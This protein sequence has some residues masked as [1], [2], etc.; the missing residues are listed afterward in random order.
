MLKNNIKILCVLVL[1]LEKTIN[2]RVRGRR[3]LRR[4]CLSIEPL[5]RQRQ[6]P[7]KRQRTI[8]VSSSQKQKE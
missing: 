5:A 1:I 4:R 7:A 6:K 3:A 8:Q 2:V